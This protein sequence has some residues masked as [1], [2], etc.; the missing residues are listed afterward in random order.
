[1]SE[2]P[3]G[4]PGAPTDA[5]GPVA[6]GLARSAAGDQPPGP[7]GPSGGDPASGSFV[8]VSDPVTS[9]ADQGGLVSRPVV[10][11]P[12][13]VA[14][15][16]DSG[17]SASRSG[18]GPAG[19]AP[20]TLSTPAVA[21]AGRVMG[22]DAAGV[23]GADPEGSPPRRWPAV[24]RAAAWVTAIVVVIVVMGVFMFP[25]RTWLQQ[26]H[27][28][29]QTAQEV[30]L[31]DQQN[32]ALTAQA[33]KLQ[34]DAE[35]ER[36]ARQKYELVRPGDEVFAIGPAPTPPTTAPPSDAAHHSSGGVWHTLTSWLP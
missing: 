27:Q 33:A 32:A 6:E 24:A 15:V 23:D 7:P 31:L 20:R 30:R 13:P 4:E 12:E 22:K 21:R 18:G 5:A 14:L 19:G 3:A 16:S 36:L 34:T 10:P 35:V 8:A 29:A 9:M 26:R 17:G 11:V 25:T 1:M 28:L 2:G